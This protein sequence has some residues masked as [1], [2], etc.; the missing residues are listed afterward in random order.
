MNGGCHVWCQI[1]GA[2]QS[3]DNLGNHPKMEKV[4]SDIL[5]LLEHVDDNI[6]LV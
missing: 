4:T 1:V 6:S 5:I 2:G 3:G